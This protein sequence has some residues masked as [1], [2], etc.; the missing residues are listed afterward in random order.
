MKK[1]LPSLRVEEK[2]IENIKRAIEKFNLNS[3]V[4]LTEAGFR[5]LAYRVLSE[6]ILR[7]EKIP[8]HFK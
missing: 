5:R 6:K 2:D 3:I 7:G 1:T 8:L 4:E